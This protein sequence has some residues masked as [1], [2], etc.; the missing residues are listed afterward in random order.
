MKHIA[1]ANQSLKF[2][3][4]SG[5]STGQNAILGKGAGAG[6]ASTGLVKQGGKFGKQ[7]Q[8]KVHQ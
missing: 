7:K 5:P 4:S 6:S 1:V 3:Q 8:K 2:V